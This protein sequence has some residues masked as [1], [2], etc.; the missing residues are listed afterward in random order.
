[1]SL[2]QDQ[3]VELIAVSTLKPYSR[4]ARS[5]SKAQVKQIATSIE[6]FGFSTPH[7]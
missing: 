1:M 3:R 4:N 6:R 5:H 7:T 2:I